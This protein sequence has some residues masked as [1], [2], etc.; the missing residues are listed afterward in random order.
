MEWVPDDMWL[1]Y[2]RLSTPAGGLDYDLAMSTDAKV[3]PSLT[4]V[5]FTL[6][7]AGSRPAAIGAL[8][9]GRPLWPLGAGGG[10]AV[11]TLG[12]GVAVTS[13]RRASRRRGMAGAGR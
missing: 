5:G 9:P 2:L 1:T 13:W 6:R 7:S 10:A 3:A 11:I 4:D 8:E 12:T